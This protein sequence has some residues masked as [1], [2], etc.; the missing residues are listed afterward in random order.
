MFKV[1]EYV[2]L[3]RIKSVRALNDSQFCYREET[4][5]VMAVALFIETISKYV[6]EGSTVYT[7]FLDLS[8]AFERVNHRKLLLK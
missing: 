3:D 8:K 6:S 1:F 7:N 4:S 5:T 2:L